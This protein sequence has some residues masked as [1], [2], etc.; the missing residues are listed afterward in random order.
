MPAARHSQQHVLGNRHGGGGAAHRHIT[1]IVRD[2]DRMEEI[3]TKLFEGRKVYDSGQDTFSLVERTLF[4]NRRSR[5]CD[6]DR[7][8]ERRSPRH[9]KLQSR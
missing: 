8:Y 2:L 7:R 5:K 1:F 9:A 3:V 6:L 4:P